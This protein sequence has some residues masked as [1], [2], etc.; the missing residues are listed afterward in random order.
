MDEAVSNFVERMGLVMEAD[1]MPRIAG[2][3]FGFLLIH[4]GAHSLDDLA[5]R[6]QVSKASV[7]TNARL[8]EQLGFLERSAAPGDRR[9]YYRMAADAWERVL[10]VAQ[11]KWEGMRK[12]LHRAQS[13]LPAELEAGRLRLVVAE[14]FHSL[15]VEEAERAIKQWKVRSEALADGRGNGPRPAA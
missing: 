10:R 14:E 2:R 11:L 4:D 9:D 8:L 7:S 15:L 5:E 1:G 6:L 12:L 3:I 13:T